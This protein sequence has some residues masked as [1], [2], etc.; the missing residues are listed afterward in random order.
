MEISSNTPAV[1]TGGA[2]GLT[3]ANGFGP[4]RERG[5]GA[6]DSLASSAG[7]MASGERPPLA[8]PLLRRGARQR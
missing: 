5:N 2:S 4:S 1:V 7:P 3:A 6:G 8:G